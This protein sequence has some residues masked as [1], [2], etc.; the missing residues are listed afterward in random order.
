MRMALD[1]VWQ[2][3]LPT[4]AMT[5]TTQAPSPPSPRAHHTNTGR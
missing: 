3:K 1:E 5:S 4:P 2:R